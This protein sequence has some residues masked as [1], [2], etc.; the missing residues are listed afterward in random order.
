[1]ICEMCYIL[2]VRKGKVVLVSQQN[3]KCRKFSFSCYSKCN[4]KKNAD[5]H[6]HIYPK[7]R[8]DLKLYIRLHFSMY[9]TTP[10]SFN[11]QITILN[12]LDLEETNVISFVPWKKKICSQMS[13]VMILW[14]TSDRNKCHNYIDTNQ[15]IK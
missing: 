2:L 5:R 9:L 4:W 12:L 15:L 7:T 14:N 10:V 13:P 1:M 8:S 3:W 6:R 11:Y